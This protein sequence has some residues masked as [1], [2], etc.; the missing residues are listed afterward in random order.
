MTLRCLLLALALTLFVEGL[1]YLVTPRRA[2]ALL[3]VLA[4]LSPGR[5]RAIGAGVVS[6]GFLLVFLLRFIPE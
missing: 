5:L 3:L 6:I 1:P 2:R 4:G